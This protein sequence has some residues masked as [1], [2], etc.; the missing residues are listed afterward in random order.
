TPCRWTGGV[1]D[2][3]P[4]AAAAASIA[5]RA[6]SRPP[7]GTRA[8][9]SPVKGSRSSK[10]PPPSAPTHSPAMNCCFS[11]TAVGA[12]VAISVLLS[13]GDLARRT[14]DRLD[15][16]VKTQFY[17]PGHRSWV[18]AVARAWSRDPCSVHADAAVSRR[19]RVGPGSRAQP[20]HDA[21]LH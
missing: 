7:A 12:W 9:T 19:E 8:T 11:A 17:Y 14:Y 15:S 21:S 13:A 2:H 10:V 20:Q 5:S 6:S 3:S 16:P 18:F 1:C 4:K